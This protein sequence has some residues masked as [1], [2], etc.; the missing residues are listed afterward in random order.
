MRDHILCVD[1]DET[2]LTELRGQLEARFGL[3]CAV[4]TARST[5]Q[6]LTA[7]DGIVDGHDA[8]SVVVCGDPLTEGG[9]AGAPSAGLE[10]LGELH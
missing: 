7:V 6:A 8:L 5:S 4:A 1:H 10:L 2:V 3:Y 9:V